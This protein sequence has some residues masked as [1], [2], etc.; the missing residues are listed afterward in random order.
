MNNCGGE[1]AYLNEIVSLK[2]TLKKFESEINAQKQMQ[3]NSFGKRYES[4]KSTGEFSIQ[5]ELIYSCLFG[6]GIA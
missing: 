5:N 2:D 3:I 1:Q 4:L 6:N